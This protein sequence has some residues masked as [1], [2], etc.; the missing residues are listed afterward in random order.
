MGAIIGALDSHNTMGSQALASES[1]REGLRE[2][3]LNYAQL[4][5]SLR[6]Q[7]G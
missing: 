4:Y 7:R 5:E 1:V 3:L 6:Q 2:V